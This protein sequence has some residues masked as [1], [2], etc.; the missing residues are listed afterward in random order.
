MTELFYILAA[1]FISGFFS[2]SEMAFVTANKLKLEIE[3]RKDTFRGRSLAF[4]SDNPENFLTT[5]LVGN[6]IINVIYAT[7]M[8]VFLVEPIQVIYQQ[9]AG[10]MPTTA[11]I[12]FIQTM[13]ASIIILLFGE[14]LAKAIFRVQADF[15]ISFIAVPLRIT[16]YVLSPLI[17]LTNYSSG[18]IVNLFNI[19]NERSDKVFRRQ[20]VE[21]IFRELKDSGGSQEIDHDDSEIL[22]NV[23]ELSNKR[24]RETMVPRTEI[25]AI[26]RNATLEELKKAFIES[27]FSKVPVYQDTIDDI[28]GV[29]FAYDL[30]SNPKSISQIT[31][32][33]NLIPSSKKS[34]DLLTEFRQ[35]NISVAIV[36]DEYGGTAGMVT[37]E[38]LIE[39]VVGDI[40]D[41]YDK[42]D[43]QIKK[44]SN[45]TF[46]LS[47]SV[48]L[49]ELIELHPEINLDFE[50]GDFETVAGY[51]IHY[52]GRIPKVNEELQIH[53]NTFII[54]KAT[55]SKL[56][57]VKLI[58]LTGE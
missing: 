22:H 42:E 1:I 20:D 3:S 41:E 39:E 58:T 18:L 47:G 27:G 36:I 25:V 33:V 54:T 38:D 45:N 32:P 24:V 44:L 40:Q 4:F 5:T 50:E 49:D 21:M 34:K 55:Q 17:F 30:F 15:L 29:V 56:E 51:I 46:L 11:M 14:I 57:N 9:F 43:D 35:S 31:R 53:G 19:G 2:G 28:I 26:D 23:L 37:I 6:N 7:L 52:T 12:L 16:N 48:E 8:A 10:E 13:V